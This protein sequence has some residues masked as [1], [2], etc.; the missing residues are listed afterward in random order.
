VST[1]VL[2]LDVLVK[3]AVILPILAAVACGRF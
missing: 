1:V 3:I 2:V